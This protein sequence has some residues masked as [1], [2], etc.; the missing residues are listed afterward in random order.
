[1]AKK[2]T[3][4]NPTKEER[5][6]RNHVYKSLTTM[7]DVHEQTYPQFND[8][9]GDQT[10]QQ[11]VDD[12]FRRL[13][14]YTLTREEQGKEDWQANVFD[15]VTRTKQKA[16]VASVALNEPEFEYQ[17]TNKN[18]VLST[19]RAEFSRQLVRHSRRGRGKNLKLETFFEAWECAGAGTVITYDGYRVEKNKQKVIT[20]FNPVNGDIET[21][22]EEVTNDYG[23][24]STIVPLS[25]FYIWDIYIFDVQDQPRV[26]WVQKYNGAD[27]KRDFGKYKNFDLVKDKK[28]VNRFRTRQEQ[29][30]FESWQNRVHDE[31]DYEVI[32]FYDKEHDKY[33]IWANGIPLLRAP[34]LNGKKEKRYPFSKSILEPFA[35]KNFFYGKSWPSIMQAYQ[36]ELNISWNHILDS[37]YRSLEPPMLV[38]MANKDLLDLQDE[39]MSDDGRYYVPDV[40]QVKPWPFKGPDQGQMS[41]L[42][43]IASNIDAMS[44]GTNQSAQQGE[45]VTARETLIVEEHA[46]EIKGIFF[47]FLEDLWRQKEELRIDN[48]YMHYMQPKYEEIIGKDGTKRLKEALNIF[49]IPDTPLSDG[50]VGTLAIQIAGSED[51][52]LSLNEIEGRE[53]AMEE[54][55][56]RPFK[57][58]GVTSDYLDDW[59]IDFTIIPASIHART[60]QRKEQ[61]LQRKHGYM[62]QFFPEYFVSNKEKMFEEFLNVYEENID[63]YNAPAQPQQ[64]QQGEQAREQEGQETGGSLLGLE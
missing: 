62:G 28:S 14:G 5:E 43:L 52:L 8:D 17:A 61:E 53:E 9:G 31:D 44:L 4:Y 55:T 40:N 63:E 64:P 46:D 16:L 18:G 3:V 54:E 38:G 56:G 41:I 6:A 60:Q 47:M 33:E 42:Q 1:M 22:E 32:R 20:S 36:D 26:A 39:F 48:V 24:I 59:D 37:F 19:K 29:Y 58:I 25:E 11:Y 35:Q 51:N 34:I 45:G 30:F 27:L 23:P 21:K 49:N 2:K 12:S 10:L 57:L 7:L 13:N 15:P 50:S